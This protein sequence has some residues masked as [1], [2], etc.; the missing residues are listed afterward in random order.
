MLGFT[1]STF[2]GF[3]SLRFSVLTFDVSPH[4]FWIS[5]FMSWEYLLLALQDR[6]DRSSFSFTAVATNY[7]SS[8]PRSSTTMVTITVRDQNDET[9]LFNPSMYS[10]S[11]SEDTPTGTT[12]LAVFATDGDE[13]NVNDLTL[14][15]GGWLLVLVMC[16]CRTPTQTSSS[17]SPNK[18]STL[19]S[20]SPMESWSCKTHS[21]TKN[22]HL[23]VWVTS[24]RD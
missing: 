23:L 24:V 18:T 15:D 19:S 13:V 16:S 5:S 9:P 21:T 3:V 11:L 17:P 6:E 8:T 1:L 7:L 14:S 10:A 22:K 2:V 4:L 12:V 20:F